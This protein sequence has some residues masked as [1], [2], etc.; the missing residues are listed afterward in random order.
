MRRTLHVSFLALSVA[1]LAFFPGAGEVGCQDCADCPPGEGAPADTLP[2]TVTA[3]ALDLT[4]YPARIASDEGHWSFLLRGRATLDLVDAHLHTSVGD[5]A[6]AGIRYPTPNGAVV[7]I[8]YP[9][10]VD[11]MVDLV[12]EGPDAELARLPIH[13][14]GP[15]DIPDE[16]RQSGIVRLQLEEGTILYPLHVG[17]GSSLV[18]YRTLAEV[19]GDEGFLGALRDLGIDRLRKV[20]SRFAEGDTVQWDPKNYRE[21]H[22]GAKHLRMYLVYLDPSQSEEAYRQVLRGFPHVEAAFLNEVR[23]A[24]IRRKTGGR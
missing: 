13:V 6:A 5:F 20:M 24:A 22:Y 12:L 11:T 4:C 1:W 9:E 18:E 8:E 17:P 10:L 19:T 14:F 16:D 23:A 15:V 21:L 2:F 7:D 3:E